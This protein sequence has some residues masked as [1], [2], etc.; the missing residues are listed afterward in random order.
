MA[1]QAELDTLAAL[2][3]ARAPHV[4]RTGFDLQRLSR[5]TAGWHIQLVSRGLELRLE[6]YGT[7]AGRVRIGA[8]FRPAGRSHLL[9]RSLSATS[10]WAPLYST[11]ISASANVTDVDAVLAHVRSRVIG[12]PRSEALLAA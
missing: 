3:A 7:S 2:L 8:Q 9:A 5:V 12:N 4:I 10:S 1:T 11:S 6:V